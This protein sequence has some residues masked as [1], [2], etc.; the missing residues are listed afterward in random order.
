[1]V[2]IGAC[3]VSAFHYCHTCYRAGDCGVCTCCQA[4]QRLLDVITILEGIDEEQHHWREP[5]SIVY[6]D[7]S[8]I[9]KEKTKAPGTSIRNRRRGRKEKIIYNVFCN[10][11]SNED[12]SGP[13]QVETV[14]ASYTQHPKVRSKSN[15]ACAIHTRCCKP[16]SGTREP[17]YC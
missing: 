3:M 9:P 13:R 16:R 15:S 12:A 5:S 1:M 8:S 17:W 11:C 7:Q 4:T 2:S 14:S 6:K 10:A